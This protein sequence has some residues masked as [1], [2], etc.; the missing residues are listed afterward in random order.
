MMSYV[1]W[2]Y[3][4]ELSISK[5]VDVERK[6]TFIFIPSSLSS[7]LDGRRKCWAGCWSNLDNSKC[8]KPNQLPHNKPAAFR[9]HSDFL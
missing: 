8:T 9:F 4:E 7:E 1:L 6:S 3:V 5:L 2:I